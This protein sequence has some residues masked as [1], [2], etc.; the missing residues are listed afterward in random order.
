[1]F[2]STSVR[3][4]LEEPGLLEVANALYNHKKAFNTKSLGRHKRSTSELAP[5][6]AEIG[7]VKNRT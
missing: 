1:M 3:S 5:I 7:E 4:A 2:G 6:M